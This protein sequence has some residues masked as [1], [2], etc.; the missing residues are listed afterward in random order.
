VEHDRWR[1]W[2]ATQASFEG[3]MSELYG[4]ELACCLGRQPDSALVAEGS[5]VVVQSG[6]K[7]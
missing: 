4:A 7:I 1:V 2:P 3:E 5:S 6:Q